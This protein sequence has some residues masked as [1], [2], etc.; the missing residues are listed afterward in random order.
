M[1]LPST[2]LSLS[3]I[4]AEFGGTNPISMSEYYRGGS[5]VPIGT[6]TSSIDGTPISTTGLIRVG[7]FRGT[8]A[9][10]APVGTILASA[11]ISASAES[12]PSDAATAYVDFYPDGTFRPNAVGTFSSFSS[13]SGNWFSPTNSAAGNFYW[14]DVGYGWQSLSV[15]R[16]ISA[17][18]QKSSN[19]LSTFVGTVRIS[20]S[21]S[22]SPVV[23]NYSVSLDAISYSYTP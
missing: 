6:A 10:V 23:A 8:S 16:T 9:V 3:A 12:L 17:V 22:G 4:Q 7:M 11:T 20:S 21:P 1:S 18:S 13:S 2:S 5:R 19:L 14:I 15:V